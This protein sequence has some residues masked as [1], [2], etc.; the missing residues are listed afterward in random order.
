MFGEDDDPQAIIAGANWAA[1][2]L[3]L[4]AARKT[5]TVELG[6]RDMQ[7][8]TRWGT[9]IEKHVAP[10][11]WEGS[12]LKII[13]AVPRSFDPKPA[14]MYQRMWI[15]DHLR[16]QLSAKEQKD[17]EA[18]KK[19][20]NLRRKQEAAERK[21]M[22]SMRS[23]DEDE[24]DEEEAKAELDSDA[25]SIE[26]EVTN[27]AKAK[28]KA[29]EAAGKETEKQRLIDLRTNPKFDGFKDWLRARDWRSEICTA[30]RLRQR[31][32]ERQKTIPV[33]AATP[34][35]M[36]EG[37]PKWFRTPPLA[38]SFSSEAMA[39]RGG[40]EAGEP[41][42]EDASTWWC[43]REDFVSEVLLVAQG[44]GVTIP[45]VPLKAA[46]K[47]FR[48][49]PAFA[50][51]MR[52]HVEAVAVDGTR[53]LWSPVFLQSLDALRTSSLYTGS[54]KEVRLSAAD[55][56]QK[57]MREFPATSSSE[58][59]LRRAPLYVKPKLETLPKADLCRQMVEEMD[60]R[61]PGPPPL[62]PPPE[63][64]PRRQ[65]YE[66]QR[67]LWQSE[68][69]FRR[70]FGDRLA[71]DMVER[72]RVM[73]Q[74][75]PLSTRDDSFQFLVK[76]NPMEEAWV[77]SMPPPSTLR[78]TSGNGFGGLGRVTGRTSK[79]DTHIGFRR[80]SQYEEDDRP[81]TAVRSHV[82]FD[83]S[84]VRSDDAPLPFPTY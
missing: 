67:Q 55:V 20:E 18:L 58:L 74:R 78:T 17:D 22:P 9:D 59:P 21:A 46:Q 25:D 69:S 72:G 2:A 80:P 70:E 38:A 27:K 77:K 83:D 44:R 68:A 6:L 79:S 84:E 66:A 71:R 60:D 10:D 75:N 82:S 40:P 81:H 19:R 54:D 8:A 53:Q 48:R 31:E 41:Q 5:E 34:P 7:K 4:R 51:A 73:M 30:P 24:S 56:E 14:L 65:T 29:M 28:K 16:D 61:P 42:I 49:N 76:V 11:S 1:S 26:A 39:L 32:Q 36:P 45:V 50:F 62:P 33:R 13:E 43:W 3:T 35:P 64:A 57:Y 15:H 52:Q 47:A 63:L 12:T 23:A 37:I